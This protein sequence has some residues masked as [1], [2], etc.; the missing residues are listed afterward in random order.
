M[1]A[2]DAALGTD[3]GLS[4]IK[5][6]DKCGRFKVYFTGPAGKAFN[7]GD[8]NDRIET[9]PELFWLAGRFNEPVYAWEQ[10]RQLEAGGNPDALDLLWYQ[11]E[12][13]S[14]KQEGWPLNAI[15]RSADMAFLRSAWED[16]NAIFVAVKGG[17]NNVN[18]GHLD[19]GN[20]V[21]D[22][23]GVRWAVDSV[24]HSMAAGGGSGKLRRMRME[25]YNTIAMRKHRTCAAK[26]RSP[27]ISSP[28]ICH[29]WKSISPAPIAGA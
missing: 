12:A 22:A 9:S 25:T 1:A 28:R 3:F 6:F 27:I 5:G 18:H 15:F 8:A 11:P 29:G 2:L 16:P 19:A 21:L 24:R 7:Y 14:P 13:R 17:D 26:P 20:F 23:G 4:A 10:Q